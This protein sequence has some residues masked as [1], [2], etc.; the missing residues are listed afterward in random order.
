MSLLKYFKP[1]STGE[2]IESS[3][4]LNNVTSIEREEIAIQLNADKS[5]KRKKYRVWKPEERAEIGKLAVERGNKS[6]L[7]HLKKKYPELTR[8][9]L[10]DF[11]KAY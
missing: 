4:V 3:D 6:A 8:H 5:K 2:V 9:T 10:S 7:L 11:S 1:V